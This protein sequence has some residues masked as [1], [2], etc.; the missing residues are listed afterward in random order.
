M[1]VGGQVGGRIKC[2]VKVCVCVWPKCVLVLNGWVTL[3]NDVVFL[4][5]YSFYPS[6]S[7]RLI[8]KSVK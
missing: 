5:G 4:G 3:Q 7:H 8:H 1:W 6:F 2:V